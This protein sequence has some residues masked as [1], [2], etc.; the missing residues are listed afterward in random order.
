MLSFISFTHFFGDH[1]FQQKAEIPP[2]DSAVFG[3]PI[4]QAEGALFQTLIPNGQS[5]AVP[6]EQF[7][8]VAVSVAKDEQ[9]TG[10]RVL[11]EF[12]P[13]QAAQTIEGLPQIAGGPVQID[14]GGGRQGKH[15]PLTTEITWRRVDES[16]PQSSS[17]EM[18]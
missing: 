7:D 15:D 10:E 12:Q 3:T 5:V 16:K 2:V 1:P 13:D 6:I 8:P 11:I 4:R 17:I 14:P 9:G 18:P